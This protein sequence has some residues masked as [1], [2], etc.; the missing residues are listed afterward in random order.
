MIR[1][2]FL[3]PVTLLL[4]ARHTLSAQDTWTGVDRV[5]AFGDVH[6]YFERFTAVLR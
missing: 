1:R 2:W 4:N 5:V 3:P 6:G